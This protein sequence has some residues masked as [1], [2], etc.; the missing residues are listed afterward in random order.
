MLKFMGQRFIAN[1]PKWSL[2]GIIY[3]I[4]LV[5]KKAEKKRKERRKD[6]TEYKYQ[7]GIFK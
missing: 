1:K 5:Q 4:H 2:Y 3:K 7:D 6:E